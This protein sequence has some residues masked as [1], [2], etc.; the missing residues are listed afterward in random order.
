M[1]TLQRVGLDAQ[2][3]FLC[4]SYALFL[5]RCNFFFGSSTISFSVFTNQEFSNILTNVHLPLSVFLF[6]FARQSF[7]F[8]VSALLEWSRIGCLVKVKQ[9][10]LLSPCLD[11]PAIFSGADLFLGLFVFL[12]FSY[13]FFLARCNFFLKFHHILFCL[14]SLPILLDM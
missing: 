6:P 10:S 14:H 13:A 11:S 9:I 2:H 3:V 12:C 4:F 8:L 1:K 5:A 7:V